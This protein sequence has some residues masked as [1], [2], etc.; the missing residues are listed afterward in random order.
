LETS[1][2]PLKDC[3]KPRMVIYMS[4]KLL[5]YTSNK[6]Q[7]F[8]IRKIILL[9][10]VREIIADYYTNHIKPINT[11]CGHSMQLMAVKAGGIY[12]NHWALKC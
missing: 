10:L 11:V 1:Q 7:N 9:T 5:V 6:T 4:L 3:G 2:H 8:S 12:S